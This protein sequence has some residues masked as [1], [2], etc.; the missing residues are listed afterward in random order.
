MDRLNPNI[1]FASEKIF[2]TSSNLLKHDL[3]TADVENIK[4]KYSDLINKTDGE[5]IKTENWGLLNFANKI[6][7]FKKGFYIHLKFKGKSSTINEIK[8]RVKLDD[9]IIRDLIVKYKKLDTEKEYFS[10]N[11]KEEWNQKK[12]NL[13]KKVKTL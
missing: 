3:S 4:K 1:S 9:S 7:N 13:I 2:F 6:Q 10:K 11:G 5:L 12:V 8:K